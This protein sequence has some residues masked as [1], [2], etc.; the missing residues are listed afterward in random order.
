[1]RSRFVEE[2]ILDLNATKAAVRAG[3]S[4]KTAR[5]QGS[6]LLSRVDVREAIEKAKKARAERIHLDQNFV[7]ERLIAEA[8]ATGEGTTHA[9]RVRA[10]ELLGKH[11]SMF[12]DR[13]DVTSNG[14]S[15]SFPKLYGFDPRRPIDRANGTGQTGAKTV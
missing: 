14:E 6:R 8:T 1:M 10:L 4:K 11:Q 12:I 7:I 15:I 3:F 2:F 13:S 5:Q 9:A